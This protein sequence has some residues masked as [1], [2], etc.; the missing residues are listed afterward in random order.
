MPRKN[1]VP[2]KEKC[3]LRWEYWKRSNEYNQTLA[4]IEEYKITDPESFR[5]SVWSNYWAE[6]SKVGSNLKKRKKGGIFLSKR[7]FSIN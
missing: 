6:K 4:F 2:L 5:R 3:R 1:E 7:I